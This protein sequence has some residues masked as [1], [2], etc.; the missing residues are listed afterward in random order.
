ML[1]DSHL[2]N[3]SYVWPEP[4]VDAERWRYAAVKECRAALEKPA[5]KWDPRATL[6]RSFKTSFDALKEELMS[7]LNEVS[8][9][10]DRCLQA[11]E[12]II[13]K[14]AKMWLDFG[15]QRC[16]IMVVVQGSNLKS[17]Q[18]KIQTARSNTL[19]L[20]VVPELKKFGNSKGQ[21]VDVQETVGECGGE[22]VEVVMQP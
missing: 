16:R 19:K 1:V 18:E 7:R 11:V 13:K 4:S 21:D 3:G 2:D 15:T 20:V 17:A 9:V 10:D 14:A 8:S 22:I 6:K 12:S 5:S